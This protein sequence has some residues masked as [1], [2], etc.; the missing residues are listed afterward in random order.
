MNIEELKKAMHLA[1]Q[2][3]LK[4]GDDAYTN[5]KKIEIGFKSDGVDVA[6]TTDHKIEREFS[7]FVKKH[8]PEHGFSGEEFPELKRHAEYVWYIDPIDGTKFYSKE[9]P[10]WVVSIALVRNGEPILGLI[11]NPFSKQ[12]YHAIQGHGAFLG[13]SKISITPETNLNKLQLALDMPI[14]NE[15][16]AERKDTITPALEELFINFYRIRILG[17]G[18]DGIVWLA[19][20]F[21]GC[22]LNLFRTEEKMYDT[23]TGIVIA[24]EA[25]AHIHKIEL[26][27]G[28]Y[29]FIFGSKS[30]VDK[31]I[32]IV[33]K[34]K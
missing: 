4:A 32:P 31:L 3:I 33:S 34:I 29:H 19:Q 15:E 16:Y 27:P 17:S 13:D 14:S 2:F 7:E 22:Y 6:T 12:L 1:T 20:G 5:W 24:K 9:V 23:Y 21:F 30:V 11:Y 28:L 8:F 10:L 26:S 25:G 18:A